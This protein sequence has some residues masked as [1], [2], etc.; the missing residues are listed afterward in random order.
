[1]DPGRLRSTRHLG[2][3]RRRSPP[4]GSAR[5]PRS[6][7]SS[8]SDAARAGTRRAL[9]GSSDDPGRPGRAGDEPPRTS[10]RASRPPADCR[11]RLLGVRARTGSSPADRDA[12]GT[13]ST[14]DR[15]TQQLDRLV[16]QLRRPRPRWRPAKRA[17]GT[18]P[19]TALSACSQEAARRLVV[20]ALIE[21]D[22]AVDESLVVVLTS[23][24]HAREVGRAP[25]PPGPSLKSVS[26]RK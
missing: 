10:G 5:G 18:S 1:M 25:P 16:L 11:S 19:D 26:P 15:P 22:A 12:W 2:Q 23:L 8:G 4:R 3:G 9:S 21:D 7:S 17:A 13:R 6:A 20:A 24:Q 14:L